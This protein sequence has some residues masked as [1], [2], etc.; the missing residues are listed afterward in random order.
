MSRTPLPTTVNRVDTCDREA[1]LKF[2]IIATAHNRASSGAASNRTTQ[3]PSLPG[4][5]LIERA[6]K[7][8]DAEAGGTNGN[9]SPRS[10]SA[11]DED[12]IRW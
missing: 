4:I 1:A 12:R 3:A 11:T 2:V 5:P 9:V 6:V 10:R 7:K 8:L